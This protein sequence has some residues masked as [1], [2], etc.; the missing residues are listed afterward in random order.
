MSA[1]TT[2]SSVWLRRSDC[3]LED[4]RASVEATVTDPADYPFAASVERGVVIYGADLTEKIAEAG[5]RK[6]VQAEIVHALLEGPGIVVFQGAFAAEVIDR[7]SDA[8]NDMLA[9]QK[10]AGVVSGDHFAKAGAND[11]IWGAL[12]KLAVAHPEVFFDYYTND[13]VA[14]ASSAWLGPNYQLNSALNIVN[15]GGQAQTPHRDYHLG[16]MPLETAAG[17]P[18]HVHKLSAALT[19]QG[20]VAHCDMPIETGPTLYLPHSQKYL[21]GYLA[22]GLPDFVEY[23]RQHYVQLPLAKGDAVFFNPALFHGA[24]TNLTTDVKRMANLLQVSSAFG[25]S[26]ETVNRVK[27]TA[28]LYP[29][30]LQRK[31]SGA[32]DA[33]IANVIAASAE[34]YPFPTNLDLDQPVDSLNPESQAELVHR[35]LAAGWTPE[36]FVEQLHAQDGRRRS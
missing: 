5:V 1:P 26:L 15:P 12:D 35:A 9:A 29:T 25:R 11:R 28:A 10:A 31:A 32:G 8:F 24:G 19:L 36:Q 17:Y 3:T 18:A 34:G 4:F 16:F 30:L 2:S 20:A 14:L 6:D 22:A 33:E 23:F 21:P 27:A 7:A 13:I